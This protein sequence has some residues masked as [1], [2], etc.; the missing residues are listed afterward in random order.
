MKRWALLLCISAGAMP[1][2]GMDD[3][4]LLFAAEVHRFEWHDHDKRKLDANAWV[5]RDQSRWVVDMEVER[6]DDESERLRWEVFNRRPIAPFW[7]IEIGYRQDN[8]PGTA[9]S[10]F[11][12]GIDGLAPY[13]IETDIGLYVRDGQVELDVDLEHE[14][15]L[16]ADWMLVSGLEW[17]AAME[18][19]RDRKQGQGVNYTEVML[20]LQY[21][22]HKN[23]HPYIGLY[24]KHL[25]GQTADLHAEDSTETS[26]VLGIS[27]WF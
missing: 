3:D 13:F 14:L 9:A 15:P 7:D 1:A 12:V 5:G 20:R 23:L 10:W 24:S 8:L 22:R 11:K 16:S 18:S 4:P 17:V 21:E 27:A 19:D 2:F 25:Y 26:F 6:D